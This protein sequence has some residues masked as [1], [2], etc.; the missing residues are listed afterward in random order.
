MDKITFEAVGTVETVGM[1]D[2]GVVGHFR[3]EMGHRHYCI[4]CS[5][6]RG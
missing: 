4:D 6:A 5:R 1:S 3:I 2:G